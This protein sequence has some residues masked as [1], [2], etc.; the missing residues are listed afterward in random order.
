MHKT[1]LEKLVLLAESDRL[2]PAV[3]AHVEI[4]RD[5][6]KLQQLMFLQLLGKSNGVKIIKGV[7]GFSE[8]FVILFL[9]ENLVEGLVHGLVVVS[10][11]GAEVRLNELE[12]VEAREEGHCACVVETRCEDHQEVVDEQRLVVEVELQGLVV[13]LDVR[14]LG[15]HLLEETLLPRLRGVC[16]HGEGGVIILLVLVVEEDK[17]R[18]Q[19]CLLSS[20]Q[21]LNNERKGAINTVEP[22]NVTLSSLQRLILVMNLLVHRVAPISWELLQLGLERTLGIFTRDQKSS[23]CSLIFAGLYLE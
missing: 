6:T 13:E 16:H 14:H 11:D 5:A 8:R 21:N 15:D 7:D 10:L 2:C 18:P 23:R 22:L 3:V 12:V 19:M 20:S 9:D 4:S 1:Y 17:L